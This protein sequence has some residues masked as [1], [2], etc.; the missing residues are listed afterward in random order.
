[1]AAVTPAPTVA[2]ATPTTVARPAPAD[3]LLP[4]RPIRPKF[5]AVP[6]TPP[7]KVTRRE[8]PDG[9]SVV[10]TRVYEYEDGTRVIVRHR[11]SPSEFDPTLA[12]NRSDRPFR[13]RFL[14][15]FFDFYR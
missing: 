7:I 1:V 9:D 11:Y 5:A 4:V 6:R 13:S 15:R 12:Y 8:T 14:P 2:A 10:V 3:R